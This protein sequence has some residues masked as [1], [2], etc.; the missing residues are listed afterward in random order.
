MT[1][2]AGTKT[3]PTPIV[4]SFWLWVVSAVLSVIS[5]VTAATSAGTVAE[6]A[7][8]QSASGGVL[9]SSVLLIS[10]AVGAFIVGALH[11]LFAFFMLRGRNWARIVLTVVGILSV[12]GSITGLIALNPLSF[13]FVIVTI[14]AIV[15]MYVPAARE[16]FAAN[17]R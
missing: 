12:L 17:K 15:Q 10:T 11:V 8:E 4:I 7:A 1:T 16:Y 13:I 3:A 6:A 5:G 9:S 14:V 2:T